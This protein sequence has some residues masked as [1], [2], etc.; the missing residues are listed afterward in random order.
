[1]STTPDSLSELDAVRLG[2]KLVGPGL[3]VYVVAEA[4]V[5]HNG[6]VATA[7]K[8]VE[9]AKDAGADAVKF[10]AFR[11]DRL[12]T[13]DTAT[14]DYQKRSPTASASQYDLLRGLELW[15]DAFT[16]IREHCRLCGIDFLATPF[17]PEDVAILA[18]LEPV[19]LKIA[20]TDLTNT[21][22]LESAVNTELPL[23]VSTGAAQPEEVEAAVYWLTRRGSADRLI[24]LHCISS[25]PTQPE[26]ANLRRIAALARRF[27]LPT[28]FSDHTMLIDTGALA[29]SAGAVL[30]EK[31]FTLSR[32]QQGPDHFF[33][34]EPDHLAAY[35][36]RL[37][38]AEEM[39][40]SGRLEMNPAENQVRR[41][42][43]C[44]VV[45][46]TDIPA[47]QVLRPDMLT[48]KRPGGGIDPSQLYELIGRPVVAD[49]SAETQLSW[50]MVGQ[51]AEP[52]KP[53]IT[54]HGPHP[55]SPH[56]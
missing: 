31:H 55:P 23:I 36:T 43:R 28:G 15:P 17:A 21:P 48:V 33:S 50:N 3:P 14:V 40:G 5:N 13:Q 22:L 51:G 8:M 54:G 18:P 46:A 41:L 20:S 44:S 56:P 53:V 9:A 52:P 27:G 45:A 35:I 38:L 16:Q 42:S 2:Q 49:V 39:L 4:G 1:M 6:D 29:T 11:A 24:L 19:A 12:V 10:Q 26:D 25:Y 37:R 7:L 30:I 47:G 34:L 32:N